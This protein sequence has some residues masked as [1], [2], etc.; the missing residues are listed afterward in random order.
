MRRPTSSL[1]TIGLVVAMSVLLAFVASTLALARPQTGT[2]KASLESRLAADYSKD[3]LGIRLAPL[4]ERI[5][6]AS[7]RDS[8]NLE[9]RGGN[10][11]VELVDIFR[12]SG[13]VP[14]T[15]TMSPPSPTPIV[16]PPASVET[17]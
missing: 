15:P 17:P 2:L 8:Q 3:S 16:T 4:S 1:V 5:I 6:D 13:N 10:G 14:A 7:R 12:V 11:P 9:R